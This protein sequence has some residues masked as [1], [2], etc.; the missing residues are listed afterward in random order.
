MFTNEVFMCYDCIM[1][2]SFWQLIMGIEWPI[3]VFG[4]VH[5]GHGTLFEHVM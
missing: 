2:S 1:F 4:W 3:A 5:I